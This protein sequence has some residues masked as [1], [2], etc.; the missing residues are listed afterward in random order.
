MPRSG[1]AALRAV[2]AFQEP[3]GDPEERQAQMHGWSEGQKECR[4]K[5]LHLYKPSSLTVFGKRVTQ[6]Q[7]IPVGTRITIIEMCRRCKSVGRQADHIRTPR[8]VRALEKWRP[9]YGEYKG[10]AY[11]L[12]PGSGKLDDGDKEELRGHMYLDNF[13]LTFV[14]E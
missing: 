13:R 12:K 1:K 2:N 4:A 7:N 14:D 10:V 11:L 9:T 6:P 5:G 3:V 8:G